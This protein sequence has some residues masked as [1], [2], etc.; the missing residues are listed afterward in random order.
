MVRPIVYATFGPRLGHDL[1]SR[2]TGGSGVTRTDASRPR[3]V[4]LLL[5][6]R[7]RKL[8]HFVEREPAA[9]LTRTR[10]RS[11]LELAF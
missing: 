11:A 10:E 6:G 9:F 4:R 7:H 2:K 5:D 1:V 8:V 3:A